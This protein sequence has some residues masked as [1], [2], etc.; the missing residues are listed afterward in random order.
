MAEVFE[1]IMVTGHRPQKLGTDA[2]GRKRQLWVRERL[3]AL[4]V[5]LSEDF[6]GWHAMTGMALGVDTWWA[7]ACLE[8][9][10]PYAAA[11]PFPNQARLWRH[12]DA[13][14]YEHLLQNADETH[15]LSHAEP[16]NRRDA[17]DMLLDRNAF[18]VGRS[19]RAVAVWN[20]SSGGTSHAVKLIQG[21][22]MPC[23]WLN[24][25]TRE[26]HGWMGPGGKLW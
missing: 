11:I 4:V 6:P 22:R 14:L 15:L 7:L 19:D 20:G 5:Q 17:A 8:R 16:L 25:D 18:M 9:G 12:E 13:M 2:E 3:D 1:R 26:A 24:P 10:V 21:N 23:Y